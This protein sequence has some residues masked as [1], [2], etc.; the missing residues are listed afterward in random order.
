MCKDDMIQPLK[1]N[2]WSE[3][4]FTTIFMFSIGDIKAGVSLGIFS[5]HP[6]G[7]GYSTIMGIDIEFLYHLSV[8][9]IELRL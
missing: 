1:D 8:W 2:V 3:V 7:I 5:N 4:E 6:Y 9:T